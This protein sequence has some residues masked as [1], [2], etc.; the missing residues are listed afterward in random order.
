MPG[1]GPCVPVSP[2][3]HGTADGPRAGPGEAG[4]T[5]TLAVVRTLRTEPP[6]GTTHEVLTGPSR[7][8]PNVHQGQGRTGRRLLPAQQRKDA[9]RRARAPIPPPSQ[10]PTKPRK[11]PG[12]P[13]R[14]EDRR[15]SRAGGNKP[16]NESAGGALSPPCGRGPGKGQQGAQQAPP[17]ALAVVIPTGAGH[18]HI[19]S[20]QTLPGGRTTPLHLS[21]PSTV[22]GVGLNPQ[23]PQEKA[24]LHEGG[25]AGGS[26]QEGPDLRQG[27]HLAATA[28]LFLPR[29][30]APPAVG[31]TLSPSLSVTRWQAMSP[32]LPALSSHVPGHTHPRLALR[33][34]S[35]HVP[36]PRVCC[37]CALAP[38][39][40]R[41]PQ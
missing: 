25:G 20:L 37:P 10:D 22:S 26:G 39:Q 35:G 36:S 38:R 2:E 3:G 31:N 11:V 4:T 15:G 41:T 27:L 1:Q 7:A 13:S 24:P 34:Q 16:Q 14:Q 33:P 29:L 19:S 12:L 21:G 9:H 28:Y 8:G 32:R 17:R 6:K 23:N 5:P 18:T 30:G 40:P